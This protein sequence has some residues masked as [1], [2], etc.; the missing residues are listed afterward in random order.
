MYS[1]SGICSP[2]KPLFGHGLHQQLEAYHVKT[3]RHRIE[4]QHDMM[5]RQIG[6]DVVG[7][8]IDAGYGHLFSPVVDTSVHAGLPASDQDRP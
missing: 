4:A 7:D 6:F 3:A 1:S 8:S 5:P 2:R